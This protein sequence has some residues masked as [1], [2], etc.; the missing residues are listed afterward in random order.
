MEGATDTLFHVYHSAVYA[1]VYCMLRHLQRL[2][3]RWSDQTFTWSTGTNFTQLEWEWASAC[4]CGIH[5]GRQSMEVGLSV[6]DISLCAERG[7]VPQLPMYSVCVRLL[8][9]IVTLMYLSLYTIYVI[10]NFLYFYI[11]WEFNWNSHGL[12]VLDSIYV[13]FSTKD[14]ELEYQS[15]WC[16]RGLHVTVHTCVVELTNLLISH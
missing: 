12:C 5:T 8:W 13:H 3:N 4:T 9:L 1:Y 11:F 15:M 2:P 7:N 10:E 6:Q 16:R 14:L